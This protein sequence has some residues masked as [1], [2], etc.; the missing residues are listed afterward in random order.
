MLRFAVHR[1]GNPIASPR[2]HGVP[3]RDV[4]CRIYVSIE[5]EPADGTPED[6]LALTRLPIHMPACATALA[7]ERGIDFMDPAGGLVIQAAEQQP[8][9]GRENLPIEAG[10][11][12]HPVPRV[13]NGPPSASGH[14]LDVQPLDVDQIE[15]ARQ[16]GADLLTPVLADI[17][18]PSPEASDGQPSLGAPFAAALC[19]SQPAFQ[20]A[21]TPLARTADART[22]QQFTVRQGCAHSYP[23]VNADDP[24]CTRA[25]DGPG[26]RSEG[27]VPPAS[28]IHG[29]PEGL[30]TSGNGAGPAK[31]DPTALGNEQFSYVSVQ[32]TNV[33]RLD[34]D[35]TEPFV[36]SGLAPC[37][38]AMGADEEI[39]HRLVKV[40]ERLLLH[41]LAA[42]GQP[43]MFPSCR[44]ELPALLKVA[45]RMGP[46]R[47]PPRLLFAGKVPH[48]PCLS[49]MLPENCLIGGRREQ[50]VP[51]HAKTLSSVADIPE[52]VKRRVLH[53]SKREVT[54]PRTA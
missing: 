8:P 41:H 53:V 34:G 18:L 1:L 16:V 48:E 19:V 27:H 45:R 14:A 47:M 24:T 21:Q 33:M 20:Q 9:S 51:G 35:D 23:A 43:S 38:P 49:A 3:R 17:S 46:S 32:P 37:R 44:G 4:S 5:R 7:R 30:H 10:L 12:A 15:A 6:G 29:D 50:A 54:T 28:M 2:S 52:E 40:A 22:A 31:P 36:A 26:N 39:S 13:G 25:W 11:L 42:T